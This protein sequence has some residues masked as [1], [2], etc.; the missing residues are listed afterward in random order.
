MAQTKTGSVATGPVDSPKQLKAVKFRDKI[1]RPGSMDATTDYANSATG[2]TLTVCEFEG[3]KCIAWC[4][5][6]RGSPQ[7]QTRYIPLT[8][9]LFFEA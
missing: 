1:R 9:V 5:V 4:S 3:V 6:P 7:A 8:S 2:D